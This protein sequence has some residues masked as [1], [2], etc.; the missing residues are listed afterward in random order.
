[1]VSGRLEA[2]NVPTVMPNKIETCHD[3][4]EL[5]YFSDRD[6]LFDTALH[7]R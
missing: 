6:G 1:M 4:P 5:S 3:D 7:A 2:G